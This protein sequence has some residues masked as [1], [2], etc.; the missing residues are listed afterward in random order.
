[1]P[2]FVA[3]DVKVAREDF[4][5]INCEGETLLSSIYIP[6]TAKTGLCVVY[7]HGNSGNRL[8]GKAILKPLLERGIRV[9]SF[10]FAGTGNSGGEYITLGRNEARDLKIIIDHIK[11]KFGVEQ[12]VLWG[13]SMGAVTAILFCAFYHGIVQGIV[14]DSP[15]SS[16]EK[17]AME[18]IQ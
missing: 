9:V 18:L 7:L 4:E 5:V 1:V 15:F 3:G 14:L 11:T 6:E 8:S 12:V 17:L 13:R 10:D 2:H 16:L